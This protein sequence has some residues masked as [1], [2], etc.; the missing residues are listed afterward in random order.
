MKEMK[1]MKVKNNINKYYFLLT[2]IFFFLVSSFIIQKDEDLIKWDKN[3]KL[4][5]VDFKGEIE[6]DDQAI[7]AMCS[8]GIKFNNLSWK[9]NVGIFDL[10]AVFYKNTSWTKL[11]TNKD[12]LKH[13]QGHFD[14]TEIY[15][16]LLRKKLN[17]K[18]FKKNKL[19]KEIEE[20]F[21]QFE[22]E[23]NDYQDLYDNET[24]H[25][26]NIEKQAE[27]HLKIENQL[28]ELEKH[29]NTEIVVKF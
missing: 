1:Q 10:Y 26:K 20:M 25:S 3:Y 9:K 29:S 17:N 6:H 19:A 13:E 23:K 8:S 24:D 4:K 14:I 28:K 18:R 21:D 5:W 7:V 15:A 11:K 27:W 2:V 22:K 12:A 16:R